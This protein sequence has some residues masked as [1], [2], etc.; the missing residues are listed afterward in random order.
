MRATRSCASRLHV[1]PVKCPGLHPRARWGHLPNAGAR[2][3]SGE[4][5]LF[6]P[7]GA[8]PGT[9]TQIARQVD[10]IDATV[11]EPRSRGVGFEQ[12]D[13][14]GRRTADGIAETDGDYP[15]KGI[16]E[17]TACSRNSK[18]NMLGIAQPVR[19][20]AKGGR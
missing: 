12:Y 2:A 11:H 17:R 7:A 13:L 14:P 4:F 5:G 1:A 8:S 15:S 9:F 20:P 18:G 16:G 19:A 6:A 3:A 10:D